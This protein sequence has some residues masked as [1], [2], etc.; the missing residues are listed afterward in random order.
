MKT[1]KIAVVNL[2]LALCAYAAWALEVPVL[3]PEQAAFM[4]MTPAE[5]RNVFTNEAY[6]ARLAVHDWSKMQ[7]REAKG[8]ETSRWLRL[9]GVPN[10][11]DLGGM[12]GMD[13]RLVRRGLVFRSGGFN[14]N[15]KYRLVDD[16]KNPGK[17]R[18]DY[19]EPGKPRLDDEARR[20]Q[21]EN[22]GIKTDLDLRNEGECLGMKG[23]PLGP[24]VKWVRVTS[25]AY[26]G[27]HSPNGRKAARQDFALFLDRANYPIG[28]HCIAGAD[29]TGSLAYLLE[30]LLGVSDADM[31]LDWELTAFHNPNHKFAHAA[32]YDKLVAGFAK[33][34]GATARERAEGYVKSLGFTD[35]DIAKVREIL[36]EAK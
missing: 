36:L 22:F 3:T 4:K 30:A 31:L 28:F 29:R 23:S 2:A 1:I 11:R 7:W 10:L 35:A 16:P 8:G 14:N 6:R 26:S 5:R 17:Q 33:Y 13:G 24:D 12:R 18:R 25:S 27:F 20:F 34:P 21:R 32:R 9:P 19:Y 15:A